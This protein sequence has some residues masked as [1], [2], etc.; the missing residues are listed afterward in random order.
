MGIFKPSGENFPSLQEFVSQ[1]TQQR[2]LMGNNA[3]TL[4]FRDCVT[5]RRI[6]IDL[7]SVMKVLCPT[8]NIEQLQIKSRSC[9]KKFVW[10]EEMDKQIE[11]MP[12]LRTLTLQS[13]AGK[14]SIRSSSLQTIYNMQV[15]AGRTK[16]DVS[17][18]PH[19]NVIDCKW[20]DSHHREAM[21][22]IL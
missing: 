21:G 13:L 16:L 7:D 10:N 14:A 15:A 1:G 6:H 4:D 22:L 5:R 18:A 12:K 11:A 17:G 2:Q 9:N 3:L 19:V 8:Q 20:M